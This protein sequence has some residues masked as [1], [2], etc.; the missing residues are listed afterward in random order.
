MYKEKTTS[1]KKEETNEKKI[2]IEVTPNIVDS[3]KILRDTV[4]S[5]PKKNEPAKRAISYL[6]E[7]ADGKKQPYRGQHCNTVWVV[8]LY[9][10][11]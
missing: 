7:I 9:T 6:E 11:K 2:Y 3:L 10:G 1:F 5:L 8:R 4:D